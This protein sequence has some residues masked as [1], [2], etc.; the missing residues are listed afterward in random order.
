MS[1]RMRQQVALCLI[2]A[3][4]VAA[5][6][7]AFA[8]GAVTG[9]ESEND[10]WAQI[11]QTLLGDGNVDLGLDGSFDLSAD[12]NVLA[13]ARS[14]LSV[15]EINSATEEWDLRGDAIDVEVSWVALS[16]DGSTVAAGNK[17]FDWD[18]G[19]GI[20]TQRGSD[21]GGE[22]SEFGHRVDLSADGNRAIVTR[23]NFQGS[24][25]GEARVFDWD[26]TGWVEIGSFTTSGTSNAVIT[27]IAGKVQL[28]DDGSRVLLRDVRSAVD[29]AVV[30]RLF[31]WDGSSWVEI[32]DPLDSPGGESYTMSG[33]G[34]H[35][36]LWESD[37]G[38]IYELQ[39]TSGSWVQVGDTLTADFPESVSHLSLSADGSRVSLGLDTGAPGGCTQAVGAVQ[40]L[41]WDGSA[42]SAAGTEIKSCDEIFMN[43]S[44]ERAVLSA[45]GERVA[46]GAV[47]FASGIGA[48]RV[49]DPATNVL[50][51]APRS[52]E[53]VA[54]DG[55]VAVSWDK[56]ESNGNSDISMYTATAAP[57][58]ATCTSETDRPGASSPA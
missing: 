16:A 24:F 53:V 50:P 35:V 27:T 18:A 30:L 52:V 44:A 15:Y 13:T 2:A 56:P 8:Q 54:S 28:S 11:G 12:G 19:S 25:N 38:H 48:V 34:A 9:Q 10:G 51:S 46:I 40:I 39:A 41:D 7:L 36:A 55:R 23:S 1:L 57:G 20:W 22:S 42:W 49:W 4:G 17:I 29:N 14:E 47:G 31:E 3:V 5:L 26:G 45:D 37:A 58:G 32:A 33:D 6:S 21:L 43:Q